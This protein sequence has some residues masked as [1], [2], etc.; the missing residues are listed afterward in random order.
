MSD[1]SSSS[2]KTSI[3][4][5]TEDSNVARALE[6][7]NV[8][9]QD[10]VKRFREGEAFTTVMIQSLPWT[11]QE[12]DLIRE[13]NK[14]TTPWT[15]DF[16]YMPWNTKRDSTCGYAFVNFKTPFYAFQC[17]TGL[18]GHTFGSSSKTIKACVVVPAHVQGL[19]NNVEY[20]RDRVVC[21]P[22][23]PHRPVV[24]R[25]GRKLSLWEADS[26]MRLRKGYKNNV[27]PPCLPLVGGSPPPTGPPSFC[28]DDSSHDPISNQD[29]LLSSS[30][31]SISNQEG[32]LTTDWFNDFEGASQSSYSSFESAQSNFS[33]F[34]HQSSANSKAASV[35]G[36]ATESTGSCSQ[37]DDGSV[38]RGSEG[39]SSSGEEAPLT[40]VDM[41]VIQAFIEKF[42]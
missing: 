23:N 41:C 5:Q 18:I 15:F 20:Y 38:S 35:Q 1:T 39:S 19:A 31:D 27:D 37:S 17:A 40:D 12:E 28:R 6:G 10:I 14:V 9:Q 29:G 16:F 8:E 30:H 21:S 13:I 42:G 11:F 3:T 26:M 25:H 36:G 2:S 32:L 22:N 34:S 24:F 4:T 7:D 33:H